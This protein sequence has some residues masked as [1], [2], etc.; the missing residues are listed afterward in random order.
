MKDRIRN[1]TISLF[2]IFLLTVPFGL[3]SPVSADTT[4]CKPI[5]A[6]YTMKD[7]FGLSGNDGDNP[8]IADLGVSWYMNWGF[9][10]ESTSSALEYLPMVL[11]TKSED[12]SE[13]AFKTAIRE[14]RQLHLNAF[15]NCT[16]WLIGNE[17][18]LYNGEENYPPE[19]YSDYFYKY[20]KWIKELG[21][22]FN[23]TYKLAAGSVIT[24]P[25]I[26]IHVE[27]KLA[28]EKSKPAKTLING[29]LYMEKVLKIY[30][31]RYGATDTFTTTPNMPVD[32]F[33]LHPY[34]YDGKVESKINMFKQSVTSFRSMLRKQGYKDKEVWIT[35]WGNL[36]DDQKKIND[37]SFADSIKIMNEGIPWLT[38]VN[39]GTDGMSTDGNKLIQRWGWFTFKYLS[40]NPAYAWQHK[41]TYMFDTVTQQ[42]NN[43][44]LNYKRLIAQYTGSITP[45]PT[46]GGTLT[47]TPTGRREKLTPTPT[48]D[49]VASPSGDMNNDKK[50]DIYDI[51]E[52]VERFRKEGMGKRDLDNSGKIDKK[53]FLMLINILKQAYG[54]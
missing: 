29:S 33:Q 18:G 51:N 8:A 25:D 52:F 21:D 37:T 30:K 48:I 5:N 7:R 26:E 31:T 24:R 11:H 15:G 27:T 17:V 49:P 3:P 53:D 28:S 44:G 54:G 45:T 22:E 34:M 43:L 38:R 40:D 46:P 6:P 16:T 42:L 9:Q 39:S 50:F 13:T 20:A 10:P 4:E 14:Q 35:E 23:L 47:P 41:Y 2:A 36:V 19:T 32:V 1:I 12:L